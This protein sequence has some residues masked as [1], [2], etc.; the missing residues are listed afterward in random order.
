[1]GQL[2]INLGTGYDTLDGDKLR[3]GGTKINQNFTELYARATEWQIR[4]YYARTVVIRND[5]LHVLAS[6]VTLPYNS[7]NFDTEKAAGDWLEV[8]GGSGASA[9]SD[10]SVVPSGNLTSTDVQNALEELQADIDTVV[11]GGNGD[12]LKSVYDTN[13]DGIDFTIISI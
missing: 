7:T 5:V 6:T 1:M 3:D 10:V 2:N 8:Q 12:M 4:V 13:D 9:A 11:G